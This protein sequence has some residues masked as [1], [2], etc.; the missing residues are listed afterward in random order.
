VTASLEEIA[1]AL[2]DPNASIRL[3]VVF[4]GPAPR[5]VQVY[6]KTRKVGPL[7]FPPEGGT[8]ADTLS[9]LGQM[10]EQEDAKRRANPGGAT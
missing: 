4:G 2:L 10:V 1:Q 8:L 6:V 3:P 7:L 9:M 5:A